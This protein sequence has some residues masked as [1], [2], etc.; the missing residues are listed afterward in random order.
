MART[1][2]ARDSRAGR[3]SYQYLGPRP[4]S[5]PR[6][7]T[8]G[9]TPDSAGPRQRPIA[10]IYGTI[11]CT[12][13]DC[14]AQA[15]PIHSWHR[16]LLTGSTSMFEI[17][18]SE[19]RGHANHGWLDSYHSFSFADYRDPAARAFRPAAGHQRRPYRRRR[20]LRHARPSRHGNRHVCARR[21]AG[22]PRQHGQRLD[23][24]SRRRAAHERRHGRAAQRVQRVAG[25]TCAPAADL[26]DSAT[27][28]RSA[29]LRGKALR[30]RRQARPP[31]RGRV[32]RRP[33]RLGDDPRGRV[34]LRGV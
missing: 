3:L 9:R 24:P 1:G 12:R 33:R 13:A 23:H 29:R 2:G 7:C 20:G 28:G 34:D 27:R 14:L 21:R 19:E 31:A 15:L 16:N 10:R 11:R 25:R 32:A 26:G 5:H 6:P 8:R 30:R 4:E 17:R 18:R 22:A